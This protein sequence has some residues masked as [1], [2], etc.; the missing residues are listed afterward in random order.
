MDRAYY[1][2]QGY[3]FCDVELPPQPPPPSQLYRVVESLGGGV[4]WIRWRGDDIAKS[5]TQR[6]RPVAWR[7][8]DGS[9]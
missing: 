1:E 9:N 5:F 4:N 8:D 7:E 2:A 6:G 3:T